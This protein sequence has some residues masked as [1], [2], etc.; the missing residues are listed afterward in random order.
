[1]DS[2]PLENVLFTIK[3]N[4]VL[5]Y[6]KEKGLIQIFSSWKQKV[7][8]K[9]SVIAASKVDEVLGDFSGGKRASKNLFLKTQFQ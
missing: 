1:M 9:I 8:R 6:N 3:K 5:L 4:Q 2:C 7:A